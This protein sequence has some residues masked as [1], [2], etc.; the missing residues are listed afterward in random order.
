[1]PEQLI[2]RDFSQHRMSSQVDTAV[3]HTYEEILHEWMQSIEA[4]LSEGGSDDRFVVEGLF[5]YDYIGYYTD[6]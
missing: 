5:V 4:V 6:Y 1:M 3:I 2:S